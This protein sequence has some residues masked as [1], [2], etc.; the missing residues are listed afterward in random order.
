MGN[1]S[2]FVFNNAHAQTLLKHVAPPG[3]G[4]SSFLGSNQEKLGIDSLIPLE[5]V[6]HWKAVWEQMGQK[7]GYSRPEGLVTAM[8]TAGVKAAL[9]KKGT[10]IGDGETATVADQDYLGVR[11]SALQN[12]AHGPSADGI[13][14][15]KVSMVI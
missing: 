7:P 12:L 8:N 13:S 4:R 14:R 10:Q 15:K 2:K 9:V 3:E 5:Q 6:E 11:L 1:R